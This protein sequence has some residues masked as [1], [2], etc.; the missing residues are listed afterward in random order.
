MEIKKPKVFISQPM[1]GK[2]AEEILAEREEAIKEAKRMVKCDMGV[3]DIEVIDSFIR[4]APAGA[5]PLWCLGKSLELMA[6]ADVVYFAEGW[7]K[8]RGCQIEYACVHAYAG[9]FVFREHE[10]C[11]IPCAQQLPEMHEEVDYTGRQ[12]ESDFVLVCDASELHPQVHVG[13][14]VK[15]ED[16]VWW[17]TREWKVLDKVVAWMPLPEVYSEE[18]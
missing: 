9:D 16:K 7:H 17:R 13:R 10:R 5:K 4:D 6:D 15:I 8:A 12:E 18:D 11:W 1:H 14:C 3:S 2:S